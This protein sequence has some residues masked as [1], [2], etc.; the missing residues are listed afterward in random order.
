[1]SSQKHPRLQQFLLT[2]LC[3]GSLAFGAIACSTETET[4]SPATQAEPQVST[5]DNT[6][7]VE[8]AER[9][10]SL[11]SLIADLVASL[12]VD[13]LV[14]IPWSPVI[15]QV[16]RFAAIETVSEGRGETDLEKVVALSPDLVI[17][18]QGIHEKTLQK[19]EELD[20]D[21]LTVDIN[22]WEDLSA[23]TITLGEKVNA[24]PQPL[25]DRYDACLADVP[26]KDT[27]SLVLVS[28]Q[29]L[30]SPNKNSW[31]GDFLAKMN[32]QNLAAALQ[33]E[34][35]LDGYITLTA[36]KVVEAN[37]DS[38][39]VVDT[40]E[41]LLEQ[42]KGEPFWSELKATQNEQIVTTDYF[43]LVNPGSLVSIESACAQLKPIQ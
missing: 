30:L 5:S 39:I 9:F 40:R 34:S 33:G 28:R 7:T 14:G 35:A 38:L 6:D 42:L 4:V 32:I 3:V 17:G 12:D 10:V 43:G 23:F 11:I 20:I 22:S 13:N 19:L 24:D 18:A 16:S 41:N 1:M 15:A 8:A 37:P 36:E 21:T 25:L 29:P 26:E 31:A 27:S 2:G